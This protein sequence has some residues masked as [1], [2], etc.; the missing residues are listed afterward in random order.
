MAAAQA[1][2]GK[3][4]K[5]L[6]R[7]AKA[8]RIVSIDA[9]FLHAESGSLY[10]A[11][12]FAKGRKVIKRDDPMNRL[13]AVESTFTLTG[14]MADHRLRLASSHMLAFAA[15]L[16]NKVMGASPLDVLSQGLDFPRQT[17]WLEACAEDLRHHK[18]E[19]LVVA[20]SY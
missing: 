11:R 5:P 14:S 17:E 12:E 9:D 3:D 8:K 2:F 1:A 16:A 18:G 13:Y 7:F 6:Y 4:V 10:Y 19:C 20:G 15:A